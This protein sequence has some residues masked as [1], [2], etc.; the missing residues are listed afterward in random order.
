MF[1]SL[2]QMK[3]IL[4]RHCLLENS[5]ATANDSTVNSPATSND[6]T[7]MSSKSIPFPD[8]FFVQAFF[9]LDPR[10]INIYVTGDCIFLFKM[11]KYVDK[12]NKMTPLLTLVDQLVQATTEQEP[13]N[14]P[15]NF[16]SSLDSTLNWYPFIR[17]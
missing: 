12:K 5:T 14:S 4:F 15:K 10:H 3:I 16:T 7:F 9:Y 17:N 8:N 13:L 2:F 1:I 6:S 11:C